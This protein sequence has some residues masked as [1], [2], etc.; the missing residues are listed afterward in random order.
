MNSKKIFFIAALIAAA[1]GAGFILGRSIDGTTKDNVWSEKSSKDRKPY[2]ETAYN[3]GLIK[4][5][6]EAGSSVVS[7][8]TTKVVH[9]PFFQLPDDPLFDMFRYYG[10]P[11]NKT[12]RTRALGSGFVISADGYIITNNHV[13]ENADE[14]MVTFEEHG[15]E[16]PAKVVGND[17]RSDV[18]IIKI[19]PD[20]ALPALPLGNSDNLKVGEFVVAIGNP[21]GLEHTVTTG[22][23]SALGRRNVSPSAEHVYS[24]FIQTDASI[25]P[26]NSGGPLINIYGEAIGINTAIANGQG[27]GFAIPINMVKKILPQLIANGRVVRS[28][29][30][31]QIQS[32]TPPIAK[33]LGL[34]KS[35][36]SIVISVVPGGPADKAGLKP[37][38]VILEIEG[39][40]VKSSDDLM[41]LIGT[42]E[43]GS[44]ITLKLWRKGETIDVKAQ[45]IVAPY[46]QAGKKGKGGKNTQP[47][48]QGEKLG[49][50]VKDMSAKERQMLVPPNLKGGVLVTDVDANS[51]A[52]EA[53][54]MPGDVILTVNGEQV[55]SVADLK[56]HIVGFKKGDIA[57]FLVY[58]PKAGS[59]SVIAVEF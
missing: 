33:S 20:K 14:I 40:P 7:I 10:G 22:I 30:G 50:A 48:E 49:I 16:Y 54:L 46:E 53:G 31:V 43:P 47:G 51:I 13:V 32:V 55:N 3:N 26:G 38:D 58:Q 5:V 8:Y 23:V 18:A 28:Y 59:V 21:L 42:S 41:W 25:N 34:K 19:E 6:E 2:M 45:P 56:T 36:G 12:S 1:V 35:E 52:A 9:V 24:N 17:K 39:Q 4:L 15:K 27:I 44:S 37:E 11:Q 57:R 29:L